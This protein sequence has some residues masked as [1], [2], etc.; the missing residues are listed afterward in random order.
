LFFVQSNFWFVYGSIISITPSLSSLK[1]NFESLSGIDSI[2]LGDLK[3][4]DDI[5][6]FLFIFLGIKFLLILFEEIFSN[7]YSPTP[8]I[9]LPLDLNLESSVIKNL[10]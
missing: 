9:W 5:L 8:G 10:L 1:P 7:S 4:W 6:V 2:L 3:S